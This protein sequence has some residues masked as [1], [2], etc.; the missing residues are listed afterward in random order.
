MDESKLKTPSSGSNTNARAKIELT[1]KSAATPGGKGEKRDATS[2]PIAPKPQLEKKTREA[3]LGDGT[4]DIQEEVAMDENPAYVFSKPMHPNDIVQIVTELRALMLPEIR[5]I[6]TENIPDTKTIVFDAV[7]KATDSLTKQLNIVVRENTTLREK[8]TELERRISDL[9]TAN[10]TRLFEN[11]ALE[12]YGRRNILRVS[13]IPENDPED[14]DGIVLRVAY[15]MGVNLSPSDIDRSHRV[16]KIRTGRGPQTAKKPRDIIVKFTSYNAR[17]RLFQERKFLRE[18]DNEELKCIFLNEDLTKRRSEILFEARKLRRAKKLKSAYSSDGKIIVREINDTKHQIN[19]L[20][21][22]VQF[23]YVK[24]TVAPV[25]VAPPP[26]VEPSPSSS[27][28][29]V[30]D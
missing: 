7:K 24:T 10:K 25:G 26:T 13:G 11:D 17:N 15:D 30:V 21:D 2:P 6:I 5:N 8:C 22:L 1:G 9:E 14:T 19:T 3:S 12:Q 20:D 29:S 18:T 16:G 23:G 28:A 27:S 4:G